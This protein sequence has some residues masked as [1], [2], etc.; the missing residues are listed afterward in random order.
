MKKLTLSLVI[1]AVM[2]T[3]AAAGN[4]F[5]GNVQM[6]QDS[7]ISTDF[8]SLDNDGNGH[9]T[10]SELQQSTS[11][12]NFGKM[13]TDGNGKLTQS[14]FKQYVEANPSKF[15][16]KVVATVSTT[17]TTDA[18]LTRR[19][20]TSTSQS[21]NEPMVKAKGEE[22]SA[23]MKASMSEKFG[24]A[25]RNDDGKLSMMEIK[26]ADIDGDFNKMDQDN[27]QLITKVELRQYLEN[28]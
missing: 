1:G 21:M 19:M 13:D 2:S 15:S 4:A 12:K 8:S 17:G 28:K 14:E 9:I 3:T 26:K 24:K 7:K 20:S 22:M 18:V 11:M 25:D 6:N 23:D 5:A 16:E 27:N 10:K